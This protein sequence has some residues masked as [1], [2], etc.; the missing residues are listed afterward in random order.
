[1]CS[2]AWANFSLGV[3]GVGGFLEISRQA[4]SAFDTT[5]SLEEACEHISLTL[6]RIL[7]SPVISISSLVFSDFSKCDLWNK[8][9][10]WNKIHHKT[11]L[12]KFSMRSSQYCYGNQRLS[13]LLV[14]QIHNPFEKRHSTHLF[15]W[16]LKYLKSEKFQV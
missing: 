9:K 13:K 3:L 14:L 6:W 5:P 12:P 1:M 16:T 7:L 4:D 8:K 11:A 2:K 15:P 10:Y